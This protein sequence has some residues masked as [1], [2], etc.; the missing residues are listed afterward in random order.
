[1]SI[2]TDCRNP[3]LPPYLHIA[4][5]EA[6]V[7]PDGRVYVYGSWDR[8]D[9]TYCSRQ[10]RVFSTA[11]MLDWTDHGV[12]F[13]AQDVPWMNDPDAPRYPHGEGLGAVRRDGG[14]GRGNVPTSERANVGTLRPDDGP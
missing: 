9:E 5:P 10:Y 13:D 6:H 7:M 3:V 12:S 14:V 11:S 4:D 2:Y 8:I 1:M